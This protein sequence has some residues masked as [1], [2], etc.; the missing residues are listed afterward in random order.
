MLSN[1]NNRTLTVQTATVS[2]SH[3]LGFQQR[4]LTIGLGGSHSILSTPL[5]FNFGPMSHFFWKTHSVQQ[6]G[7]FDSVI[8]VIPN[9]GKDVAISGV[10]SEILVVTVYETEV[11]RNVN[12]TNQCWMF[13]SKSKDS[14]QIK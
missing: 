9:I 13:L 3:P 4:L 12:T 7:K 11:A 14:L 5:S 8:F 2:V 10:I 1:K 6:K